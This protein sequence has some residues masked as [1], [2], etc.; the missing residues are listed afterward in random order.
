VLGVDLVTEDGG[1]VLTSQR[2]YLPVEEMG[3][4]TGP[5]ITSVVNG[6]SSFGGG[7]S[8]GALLRSAAFPSTH[9]ID[10]Q[11]KLRAAPVRVR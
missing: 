5:V 1:E 9:S 3:L 10:L 6:A 11:P 2:V 4:V 7:L 8:P